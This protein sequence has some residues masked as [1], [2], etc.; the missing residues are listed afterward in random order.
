MQ[1][2]L[3]LVSGISKVVSRYE[4]TY[5][6][7]ITLWARSRERGARRGKSPAVLAFAD[8]D[9]GVTTE[10]E[11]RDG[12]ARPGGMALERLPHASQEARTLLRR[13]GGRGQVLDGPA[14]TEEAVKRADLSEYDV[15]HFAA[16][17]VVDRA[18][19]ER[20]AVVLA[21]GDGT[22]DGLLRMGEIAGLDLDGQLVI[23]GACRSA[24]GRLVDGEGMLGL[25]R[26]FFQ[27]GARTVV[28]SVWPLRDDETAELV[29]EFARKLGS[30][31]SVAAALAETRRG[32]IAAG[33]PPA[34]WAGLVVLGDGDLV[35]TEG[36]PRFPLWSWI[37]VPACGL[38][39]VILW[40]RRRFA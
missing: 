4:F 26:A 30:G 3:L 23:L 17:A 5:T 32:R 6:P 31:L 7:S 35:L 15:L 2:V 20:S 19:P 9:L 29:D 18:R 28:G 27:A 13:L 11:M 21:R 8:P 10:G 36:S 12:E 37:L 38:L 25:S 1:Q 34:A 40:L 16:H 22:D 14:A 33:D 24:S 39:L